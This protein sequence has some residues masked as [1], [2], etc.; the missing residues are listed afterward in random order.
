[1]IYK[2][3]PKTTSE[4]REAAE[5]ESFLANLIKIEKSFEVKKI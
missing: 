4:Y 5:L 3:F 1:M 2:S